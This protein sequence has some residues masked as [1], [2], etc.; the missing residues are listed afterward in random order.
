MG[1]DCVG[2]EMSI[3]RSTLCPKKTGD[4]LVARRHFEEKDVM[5]LSYGYLAYTTLRKKSQVMRQ[6]GA[7]YTKAKVEPF[8]R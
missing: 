2:L 1:H 4:R 8:C 5:G 7:E 3:R 6:Y